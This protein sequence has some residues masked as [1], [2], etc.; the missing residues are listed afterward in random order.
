M[1]Q[2]IEKDIERP[3][4]EFLSIDEDFQAISTM[5]NNLAALAREIERSTKKVE[6]FK[7]KGKKVSAGKITS[8]TTEV[9]NANTKWNSQAPYIFEKLQA[10]DESRL[11]HLRDIL[12]QFQMHE[13]N[14]SERKH[15]VVERCLNALNSVSTC[16]V[17]NNFAGKT[18]HEGSK[19]LRQSSQISDPSVGYGNIVQS[20]R[21]EALHKITIGCN[22]FLLI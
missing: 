22:M 14:H 8:A 20:E 21:D 4:R 10:V 17:I 9:S 1:A 15:I 19:I 16:E 2:R 11:N 18:T 5:Y 13:L 6:K 7:S 3:L 12:T